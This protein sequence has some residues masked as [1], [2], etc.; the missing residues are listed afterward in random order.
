MPAPI[1]N[2]AL[3]AATVEDAGEVLTLQLAAWVA[4]G[5]RHHTFDIP[6]LTQ[7]LD[8]LR[9]D[10]RTETALV[11]VHGT[12][13]VGTVR[14]RLLDAAGQNPVSWYV[15]RL[16]VVPDLQGHGIG[17]L[18]LARLESLAPAS[19]RRCVLTTGPKSSEN[20]AFYER[21]GYVRIDPDETVGPTFLVHLAKELKERP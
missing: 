12:R 5:R 17:R 6:P 3:R 2:V 7:T 19:A 20:I 4:E 16:G 10:L 8:E 13:I 14:G 18:L 15:G 21:H 9:E 11:A 1:V